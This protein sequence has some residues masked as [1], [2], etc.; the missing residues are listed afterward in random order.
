MYVLYSDYDTH[1]HTHT[2]YVLCTMTQ[3]FVIP[4]MVGYLWWNDSC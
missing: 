2:V 3:F 1:K 4:Q